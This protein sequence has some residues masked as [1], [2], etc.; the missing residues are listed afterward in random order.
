MAAV[1]VVFL[2]LALASHQGWNTGIEGSG[3]LVVT[4]LSLLASGFG[5]GGARIST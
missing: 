4:M 5:R 2:L 1:L 3:L